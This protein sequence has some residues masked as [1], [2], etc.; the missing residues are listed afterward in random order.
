[1]PTAEALGPTC[2][3]MCPDRKD[4]I[5]SGYA[6]AEIAAFLPQFPLRKKFGAGLTACPGAVHAIA[7]GGFEPPASGL[8][9]RSGPHR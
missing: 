3:K 1:M 4:A 7:G 5:P 8:W 9:E 2:A 6:V